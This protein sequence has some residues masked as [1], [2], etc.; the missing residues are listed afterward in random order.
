MLVLYH[1]RRGPGENM[2]RGQSPGRKNSLRP[3]PEM[4]LHRSSGRRQRFQTGEKANAEAC[5]NI[6]AATMLRVSSQRSVLALCAVLN[7]ARTSKRFA[8]PRN[9]P[10]SRY[11]RELSSLSR[12]KSIE[13]APRQNASIPAALFLCSCV[14]RSSYSMME[15]T[16]PEPTVWPPSRIAKVRPCSMA[17]GWISSMVISTLSPGM[18][19]S[20][21]SGRVM[22]PVTSVVR[23]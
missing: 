15:A 10:F 13:R 18:H 1:N 5:R 12:H 14:A 22:T 19:I 4:I 3:H 7:R 16:R 6:G 8:F 11:A 9:A 21:P 23:K 2:P 17:I 20:V